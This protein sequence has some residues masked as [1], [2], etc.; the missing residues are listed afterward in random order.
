MFPA[1]TIFTAGQTLFEVKLAG[2]GA[3]EKRRPFVVV[4]KQRGFGR[5]LGVADGD[6]LGLPRNLHTGD[7]GTRLRIA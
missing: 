5:I 6:A 7:S 4:V 1:F 2:L 3:L